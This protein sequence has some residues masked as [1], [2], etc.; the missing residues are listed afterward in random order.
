VS[1]GS[2]E[3]EGLVKEFEKGIRA[4]DGI[5]LRVDQGEVYGFLGP[6]GAG[7][8]TTVLILTTLLPA[9]AG[10]ARVGGFDVMSERFK[11]RE[12]IGASLQEVALDPMLTAREHL[13][14][15]ATLHGL[16][17]AE[18]SVRG[19]QLLERVGLMD[20]ADRRVATY[21][22]GMKRRLDLALALVHRPRIVFLDEPTGALDVQSRAAL[23]D[24]VR[25]LVTEDGVTIFLTTQYLEEADALADR[26][27]IVD[28]GRLVV[29]GSPAML[30]AEIGRPTLEI[31]PRSAN[32]HAAAAAVLARFGEH[33][34]A[35]ASGV[36]VRLAGGEGAVREALRALEGEGIRLDTVNVRAPT[37]DDVVLARTGRALEGASDVTHGRDSNTLG[38]SGQTPKDTVAV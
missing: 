33:A 12:I 37:L 15:Q 16:S 23:W 14:L 13:R 4:V 1:D 17:R 35:P 21:S 11:V 9:A 32:Q 25:S 34:V 31:V 7:K 28:H 36:A 6:N 38:Q 10:R 30:K 3:A 29:E 20:A 8:T 27:G 26:V 18:R 2:I 19:R 5:D 22:G 24:E